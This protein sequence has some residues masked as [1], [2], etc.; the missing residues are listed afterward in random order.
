VITSAY[1]IMGAAG[2]AGIVFASIQTQ[3]H[4]HRTEISSSCM[5]AAA[6]LGGCCSGR[7]R[8]LII[9]ILIGTALLQVLQNSSTSWHSFVFEF[10]GDGCVI[11][12]GVIEI[13]FAAAQSCGLTN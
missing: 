11:L 4:L 2:I 5:A 8:R 3:S 13:N 7:R 6:V 12:L 1:I 10:C 9:G